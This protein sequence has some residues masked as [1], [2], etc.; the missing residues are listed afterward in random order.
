MTLLDDAHLFQVT[1][2]IPP[3]FARKFAV[4]YLDT[5]PN[6]YKIIEHD[7]NHSHQETLFEVLDRW[8]TKINA[9]DKDGRQELYQILK[10]IQETKGWFSRQ[11]IVFLTDQDESETGRESLPLLTKNSD[12]S[13]GHPCIIFIGI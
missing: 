4:E 5:D 13:S 8:Q 6:E 2:V 10:T 11:D 12:D 3:E 7:K 1:G 9:E